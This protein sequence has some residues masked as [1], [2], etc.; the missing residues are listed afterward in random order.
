MEVTDLARR[1]GAEATSSLLKKTGRLRLVEAKC[2]ALAESW[3]SWNCRALVGD[4]DLGG[5]EEKIH[6]DG[7]VEM[8]SLHDVDEADTEDDT[9]EDRPRSRSRRSRAADRLVPSEVLEEVPDGGSST[10]M[11]SSI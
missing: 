11:L 7:N 4:N 5:D 6:M 9:Q 10:T 8:C 1:S 2:L 3:T